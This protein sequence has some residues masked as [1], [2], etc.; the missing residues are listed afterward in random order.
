MADA[1]EYCLTDA[2]VVL[3]A[4]TS[5]QTVEAMEFA[6]TVADADFTPPAEP[7]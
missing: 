5:S 7:S 4:K 2:G 1:I 3:Y 6:G